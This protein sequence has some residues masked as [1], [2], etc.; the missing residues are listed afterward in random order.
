MRHLQLHSFWAAV[1]A[2]I[3]GL[4][5]VTAVHLIPEGHRVTR[6]KKDLGRQA[7]ELKLAKPGT[8]SPA[9]IASWNRYRA[10]MT[11]A[12]KRISSVY[13][14]GDHHFERWF[15][16]LEI[17]LNGAPA[18]DAFVWR[19]R[20]EAKL[21]E[22]TLRRAP[23][24]VQIGADDSG[25]PGFNW[26]PLRIEQLDAVGFA[27]EAA[28]LH[29]VQKRF[30]ARRRIA[31][32]VLRGQVRVNRIVDF[33]FFRR[34]HD[35]IR[36]DAPLCG[37]SETV[38]WPG[39]PGSGQGRLP[40][41]FEE[42]TIANRFG[43]TFTFG[44]VLELPYSE[45]AHA[46][47]EVL[48]PGLEPSAREGLLIHLLGSQVTIRDQNPVTALVEEVP[49]EARPRPVLLQLTCQVLDF[50]IPVR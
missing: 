34:L 8:P 48:N 21:L 20:D 16:G 10:G 36:D 32:I 15:P 47:R 22:A 9:D 14:A 28:V 4:V 11:D 42:A 45:V 1:A 35:G 5:V 18:R 19:Y 27:D 40:R 13:D 49:K 33:R 43:R 24:A 25:V 50:D 41:D 26:E 30:W 46:I 2:A 7:E 44:V 38:F 29:E 37:G 39:V 17:L 3:A 31:D 12:Y 23:H 6:L